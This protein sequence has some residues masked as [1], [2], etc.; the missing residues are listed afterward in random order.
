MLLIFNRYAVGTPGNHRTRV[1]PGANHIVRFTVFEVC[2][3][4]KPRIAEKPMSNARQ[5]SK[6]KSQWSAV[7]KGQGRG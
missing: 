6:V 4:Y 5:R 1:S 3:F 2:N 7:T